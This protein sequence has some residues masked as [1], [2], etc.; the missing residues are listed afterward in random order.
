MTSRRFRVSGRRGRIHHGVGVSLVVERGTQRKRDRESLMSI[1]YP[2][3][4][5]SFGE[6][7]GAKG[8]E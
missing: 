4:R 2:D 5:Y 1:V 6:G 3:I 7:G 8:S